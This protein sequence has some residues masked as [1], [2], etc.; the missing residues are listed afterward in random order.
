LDGKMMSGKMMIALHD[1]AH[2]NLAD[3]MRTRQP[4]AAR[5]A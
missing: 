4:A 2:D 5:A 1:F 3:H